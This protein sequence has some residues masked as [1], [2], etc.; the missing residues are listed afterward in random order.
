M[1]RKQNITTSSENNICLNWPGYS[2]CDKIGTEKLPGYE[3]IW[4]CKS[5]VEMVEQDEQRTEDRVSQNNE[6]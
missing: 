4:L 6:E 2:T 1:A 5:C 3:D